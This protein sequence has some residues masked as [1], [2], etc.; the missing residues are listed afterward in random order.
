MLVTTVVSVPNIVVESVT[1][2]GTSTTVVYVVISVAV[3]MSVVLCIVSLGLHQQATK[4][5]G[6]T[7]SW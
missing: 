2:R 4:R 7:W 5:V 3:V 1:V 6:H